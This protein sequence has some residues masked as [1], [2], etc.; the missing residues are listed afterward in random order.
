MSMDEGTL[1]LA[2]SFARQSLDEEEAEALDG[3]PKP[4]RKVYDSQKSLENKL[5]G[6]R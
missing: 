1:Q 6:F 3:S 2:R 5:Q 4:L